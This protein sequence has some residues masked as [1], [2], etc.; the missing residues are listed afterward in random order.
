MM[1]PTPGDRIVVE[2]DDDTCT[3]EKIRE[4]GERVE[5][6]SRT[7]CRSAREIARVGASYDGGQ[8]WVAHHLTPDSVTLWR[9]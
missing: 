2:Y 7:P 1:K 6:H 8:V 5:V 4:S 3:I 9:G